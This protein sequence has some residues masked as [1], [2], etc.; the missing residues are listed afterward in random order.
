MLV[1]RCGH[2]GQ[3]GS[4]HLG[5][6]PRQS[7]IAVALLVQVKSGRRTPLPLSVTTSTSR[8]RIQRWPACPWLRSCQIKL[9]SN[10]SESQGISIKTSRSAWPRSCRLGTRATRSLDETISG[11]KR[12]DAADIT[13]W[14]R[15]PSAAS[16][17]SIGVVKAPPDGDTITCSS[18]A[19]SPGVSPGLRL[20]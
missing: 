7:A 1:Q 18:F 10:C 5:Q 14:R 6:D 9:T 2:F 8:F 20:G 17:S 3:G 16:A 13:T 15:C 19:N 12:K 11:T 4:L